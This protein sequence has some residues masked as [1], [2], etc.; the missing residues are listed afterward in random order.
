MKKFNSKKTA[1]RIIIFVLVTALSVVAPIRLMTQ[2]VSADKFDDKITALEERIALYEAESSRL[3]QESKTLQSMIAQLSSQKASIQ[4]QIDI[5]QYQYDQLVEQIIEIEKKIKNNQDALGTMIANMYVKDDVTPLEMIASSKTIS[6]YLDAQEHRS[7]VRDELSSTI[8]EIKQLKESLETKKAET[9][10]VLANQKQ[11]REALSVKEAEQ[12]GILEKTQNNEAI[13]RDLVASS[14]EQIQTIRAEQSA[15]F[16]SLVTQSSS[17]LLE[18]DPNKGGY[19]SRYANS[20]QDSL[21]DS[22][23]LYN[24][25]CVSYAA[26]KVHQTYGNMPY[27]GGIG[28]AWQWA[29]SGWASTDWSNY[30]SQV[31]SSYP[32]KRW[33]TANSISYGIPSGTEPKVGSVAV[34]NGTYGHVA[35]VEGISG[36][37]LTISQYNWYLP[38]QGGWGQYSEMVVDKSIFQRYIYFGE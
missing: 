14:Q 35:W 2:R 34:S 21:V 17:V 31:D 3:S 25:E 24:R 18:G 30:G 16:A 26:W 19:P 7:S 15:Y 33:H 8:V 4:A 37:K 20:A 27:W 28:H 13:Y 38:G 12:Q 32:N 22:W 11:Q 36:N 29:F 23:G 6:D 9:E 1:S 10:T 5:S